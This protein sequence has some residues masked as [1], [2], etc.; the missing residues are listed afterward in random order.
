MAKSILID[1]DWFRIQAE[2]DAEY[3]ELREQGY[4]SVEEKRLVE[5]DEERRLRN[6]LE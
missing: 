2:A 1:H 6:T 3:D 5:E 4:R